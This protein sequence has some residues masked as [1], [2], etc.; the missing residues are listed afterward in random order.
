MMI[1]LGI[2]IFSI[3]F[4]MNEAFAEEKVMEYTDNQYNFAF[5]FPSDW[6]MQKVP[7]KGEMGEVRVVVKSHGLTSVMGLVGNLETR[8]TK[9]QFNKNPNRDAIVEK[10]IDYT[11][12][13]V[14]KKSS[15][16]MKAKKMIVSERKSIPFDLG[17]KFYISTLH[18]VGERETP[19]VVSG[20]HVIPFGKDHLITFLMTTVLDNKGK[21]KELLTRVFN[22]FHLIDQKPL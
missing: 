12:E 4:P 11:I 3:I 17:I 16:E 1:K 21:E 15:R 10:M 9:E 13:Q 2:L 20:I 19:I 8:I 14:Y 5:Q 6:K 18:F 7:P 22:S